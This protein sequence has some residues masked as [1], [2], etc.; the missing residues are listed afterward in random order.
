MTN[1]NNERLTEL[2]HRAQASDFIRQKREALSIADIIAM[3]F[4]G[5]LFTLLCAIALG[6][7]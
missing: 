1:K 6:S 3:F 7:L 2:F 5:I 4:A